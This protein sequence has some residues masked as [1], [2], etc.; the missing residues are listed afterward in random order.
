LGEVKDK[1][2][3][4]VKYNW[5][6]TTVSSGQHPYEFDSFRVFVWSIRRHRYETA[7]IERNV[8]GYYPV[9]AQLVPGQEDKAFSLVLEDK[10]GT[11]YKRT[12]AFSGYRVRMVSKMPVEPPPEL[13]GVRIAGGFDPVPAQPPA[14]TNWRQKLGE[15]RHRWIGR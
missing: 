4:Q 15:W 10:D 11:L 12:Y 5:L 9:E 1:D 14:E 3:S 6:W 7:Y 2:Q 13:P 8:K